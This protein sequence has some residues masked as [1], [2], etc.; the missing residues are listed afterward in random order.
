MAGRIE[1]FAT[2]TATAAGLNTPLTLSTPTEEGVYVLRV[3]LANLASTEVVRFLA[4]RGDSV[5]EEIG[6][7]TGTVDPAGVRCTPVELYSGE[8]SIT[9]RLEQTSGT[10]RA[11]PW[12]LIQIHDDTVN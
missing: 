4:V 12:R 2:G 8:T 7:W 6:E 11:F 5:I 9:F 1:S 3:S 10:L